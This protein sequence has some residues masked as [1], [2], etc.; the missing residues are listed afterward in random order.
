MRYINLR[1]TYLLTRAALQGA[2]TWRIQCHDPRVTFHIRGCCHLTNSITWSHY[3]NEKSSDSGEIWSAHLELYDSEVTKYE[4]FKFQDDGRSPFKSRFSS[5]LP[6]FSENL[7]EEAVFH[8]ILV[9]GQIPA[10]HRTCFIVFLMQFSLR[11]AAPFV[12]SPIHLFVW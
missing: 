2:V 8:R 7:R 6:N 10:F 1:L 3:L 11:R 4:H 9:M 12:S 5:R